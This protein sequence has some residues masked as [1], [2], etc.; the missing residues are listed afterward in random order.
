MLLSYLKY[1]ILFLL[2]SPH[3]NLGQPYNEML[4]DFPINSVIAPLYLDGTEWTAFSSSSKFANITLQ[5]TVP[6]DVITDLQNSGMMGDP[7]YEMNWMENSHLWNGENRVWNYSRKFTVDTHKKSSY[8]LVFDGVKMSASISLNGFLLGNAINQFVRYIFD[9][10][11]KI[12][13]SGADA[14]ILTVI[15]DDSIPTEGRWMGCS[16]GWDWAPYS[17]TSLN[18]SSGSI[19][20]FSKGIWK[21]VYLL[22]V[23]FGSAALTY[24]TPHTKYLGKY[25]T[26]PL[27]DGDHGGFMVNVT[28]HLWVPPGGANGTLTISGSWNETVVSSP[29]QLPSGDN[30][31]SMIL[32]ASGKDLKLWWPNGVNGQGPD[33]RRPFYNI[34]VRWKSSSTSLQ[35]NEVSTSRR[36]A[37]RVFALVTCNDTDDAY[38]AANAS[39][40]G[41]DHH[42]M[43]FRVNGAAIYS[44]GANMI[45]MEEVEGRLD[46]G[47]HRI[48][49]HSAAAAHMNTLRVWGGGLYYP[50]A[51]YE[52]CDDFGVLLY[53]DMAYSGGKGVHAPMASKSQDSELRHQVRRLSHHPSIVMWDG[54]N[55]IVVTP[56]TYTYV[57]AVFVM[58]IVADEDQS[59][60]VWPS[61]PASGWVTGVNRLYGTPNHSPGGLTTKGGGH[62]WSEG[63]ETHAPY[64]LGSG[65]PTVNG[66]PTDICYDR[67][68]LVHMPNSRFNPSNHSYGVAMK[69]IYASEFGTSSTSSYE[70]L[71]AVLAKEHWGIH[72]GELPDNCTGECQVI[73]GC[74]GHNVMAQRNYACD[75]P[76]HLVFGNYT[77]VDL[78]ATGRAALQGQTYLCLL[79]Q[80]IVMK[81]VIEDRRSHNQFGALVWQLNEIWPT[82]GWGSIEYGTGKGPNVSAAL[83]PGHVRGGR[84][85]PLHYFYKRSLFADVFA[86]CGT[87]YRSKNNTPA[88]FVRSDRAVEKFVGRVTLRVYR[89][90]D[91]AATP[92]LLKDFDVLLPPGPGTFVWFDLDQPQLP[93]ANTTL[94]VASVTETDMYN[95]SLIVSEHIVGL[96]YPKSFKSH[97]VT[98][99]NVTAHVEPTANL[100]GT[101]DISLRSDAIALWVS[102]TSMAQGRFSD[103][104]FLLL[105]SDNYEVKFIPFRTGRATE[106]LDTLK[107]TLRVEH[108][109]Q[110]A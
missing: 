110:Y 32:H 79:S 48:L 53:H 38:V 6:G 102:L 66:G 14:N 77:K 19:N 42:G 5:A 41:N 75:S 81:Q 69:N 78:N 43:F 3:C 67:W 13:K 8:R 12:L 59:R 68:G 1:E 94:L 50:R 83:T 57:Y 92:I 105:P 106:D 109:A 39:A 99:V 98:N 90:S 20:T 23:P 56:N 107:K 17:Y 52:A 46:A 61:S 60:V 15:F 28:T 65:W 87:I 96:T 4:K 100:D 21:S 11:A 16:G 72:G 31:I 91:P 108:Y 9:V 25:P 88:C 80:A 73:T 86:T 26:E 58:S 55:E 71:S 95:N 7:W 89:L 10:P 84:W 18:I 27:V 35:G 36:I 22:E 34:T 104:S 70:S 103:N 85:K 51:F 24:V 63:Q 54:G 29:T 76:I 30:S 37:F 47:A 2:L 33:D 49:V 64:Q 97:I 82:N 62:I 93:D 40:D 101:I 45:P 74:T 44:R